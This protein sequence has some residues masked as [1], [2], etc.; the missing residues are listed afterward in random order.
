[1]ADMVIRGA[2][3]FATLSRALRQLGDKELR[4]ELYAGINRSAKPLTE[5]VKASTDQ[6]L[7]T[8]YAAVLS[9]SLKVKTRRRAGRDPA[10]YLVATARSAGGATR[11]IRSLNR[12]RLRHPLFGNRRWWYNQ[13]VRPDWWNDPL[14]R[15]APAVRDELLRVMEDVARKVVQRIR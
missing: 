13:R 5:Q 10:I 8:R 1:M 7:P 12:G 3:R 2:E 15:G 11:D 6:F 4:R 9:R 14:L